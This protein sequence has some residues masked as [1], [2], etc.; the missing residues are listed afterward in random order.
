[1]FQPLRQI[2]GFVNAFYRG[3][4]K[5]E[6]EYIEIISD[7][8]HRTDIYIRVSTFHSNRRLCKCVLQGSKK[9]NEYEYIQIISDK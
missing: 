8:Q 9:R 5:N 3:L 7:K 6:Y 4:K 2:D 1:M